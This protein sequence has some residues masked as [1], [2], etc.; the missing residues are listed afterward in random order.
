MISVWFS[1][2]LWLRSFRGDFVFPCSWIAL[3]VGRAACAAVL[4]VQVVSPL[5]VL[6]V[7]LRV[8]FS[9]SACAV[10]SFRLFLGLAPHIGRP[11]PKSEKF[12]S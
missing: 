6:V 12:V 8:C 4:F 9:R 2:R 11:R 1:L 5:L 3:G 10:V 7:F